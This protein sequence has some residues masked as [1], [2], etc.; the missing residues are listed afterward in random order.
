MSPRQCK[1][2]VARRRACSKGIKGRTQN[3]AYTK[4]VDRVK[5]TK[6]NKH[7]KK[8]GGGVRRNRG[9]LAKKLGSGRDFGSM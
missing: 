4:Q 2:D 6:S 9:N 5:N 8:Y 7:G 1:P 3:A